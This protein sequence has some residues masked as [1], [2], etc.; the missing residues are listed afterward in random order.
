M[1]GWMDGGS[2]KK[3]EFTVFPYKDARNHLFCFAKNMAIFSLDFALIV[4]GREF[5]FA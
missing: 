5:L 1:F 4:V 2:R 3:Q